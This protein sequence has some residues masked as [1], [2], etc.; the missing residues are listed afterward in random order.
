MEH[1]IELWEAVAAA[2]LD[3]EALLLELERFEESASDPLRFFAKSGASQ[4]RMDEARRRGRLE[5]DLARHAT[6]ITKYVDMIQSHL[7]DVV[8]FRGRPYKAKMAS[9]VKEML[10]W[11]Q[12]KRQASRT[13]RAS[14]APLKPV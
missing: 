5:Q 12:E 6:R 4:D 7:G 9:D 3:R 1:A 8:A 14:S 2:I 10:F 11:L 13:E